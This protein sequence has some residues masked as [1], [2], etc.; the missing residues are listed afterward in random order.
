MITLLQRRR[1]V[2]NAL[3]APV[4]AFGWFFWGRSA[5]PH[6][7]APLLRRRKI[8]LPNHRAIV[9]TGFSVFGLVTAL[10]SSLMA[11][12]MGIAARMAAQ[13]HVQ[14]R[15]DYLSM[16]HYGLVGLLANAGTG[17]NRILLLLNSLAA[18]ILSLLAVLALIAALC[19]VLLYTIGRGMRTSAQWAGYMAAAITVV[20]LL[21]GITGLWVLQDAVRLV[22]AISVIISVYV[23]WVITVRYAV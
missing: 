2:P 9:A 5:T 4:F 15:S 3:T 23:V 22:G 18:T 10:S 7:D 13:S 12:T 14:E 20:V 19:G 21:N 6:P 16:T 8:P 17:A 1:I 11:I